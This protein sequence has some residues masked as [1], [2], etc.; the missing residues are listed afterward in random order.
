MSRNGL[1]RGKID[2]VDPI[3]VE[4]GAMGKL[5]SGREAYPNHP[6]RHRHA[7]FVCSCGAMVSCHP[8][9]A[10]AAGR[11]ASASTRYLR[12]MAHQALDQIWKGFDGNRSRLASGHARNRAYKWLATQLGISRRECHIGWMNAAQ[13]RE[14]I[15][16][17]NQRTNPQ[18]TAA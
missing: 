11:P 8:G 5:S 12:S 1:P 18:E 10:V 6:E 4:C 3:C 13:C 17:C 2:L 7:Y 16:A 14:V 15:A 9:T